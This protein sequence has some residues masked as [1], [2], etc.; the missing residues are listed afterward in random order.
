MKI[1]LSKEEWEFLHKIL[2]IEC[3]KSRKNF[4]YR[5]HVHDIFMSEKILANL[6]SEWGDDEVI[7][8]IENNP[9]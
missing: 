1:D 6:G 8:E 7:P 4:P 2:S 9:V 5:D 3:G